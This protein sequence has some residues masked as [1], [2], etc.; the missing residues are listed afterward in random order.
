MTKNLLKFQ[1]HFT[2]FS[3]VEDDTEESLKN[4]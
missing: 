2:E 4:C 3:Q 1:T